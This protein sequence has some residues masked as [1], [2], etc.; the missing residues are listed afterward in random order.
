[1]NKP[2]IL[3][4]ITA[5]G[6]SKGLPGKNIKLLGGKPLIAHTIS[7]AQKRNFITHLIVSTDDEAVAEI[8]RAH[9]GIVPFLRPAELAQDKTPHLPV[10]QHAIEF[11]EK[12]IGEPYDY[13]VIL[14]PTSPFRT[15]EDTDLTIQKMIDH[16]AQ[17]AV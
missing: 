2:R 1:M 15:V 13:V 7:V 14:Q 4:V 6:G 17:S 12:K 10:M 5:R 11:M 9:G 16:H 3:A 8:A